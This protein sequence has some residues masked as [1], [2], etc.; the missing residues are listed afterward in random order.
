MVAGEKLDARH[1]E[2]ME[3]VLR[4]VQF[5][6]FDIE[7]THLEDEVSTNIYTYAW[8][9]T[10]HNVKEKGKIFLWWQCMFAHQYFKLPN[11]IR[12]YNFQITTNLVWYFMWFYLLLWYGIEMRCWYLA[13]L[14]HI[15]S[16][17]I[18]IMTHMSRCVMEMCSV[19]CCLSYMISI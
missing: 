2:A 8:K 10:Q 12:K 5:R 11:L 16:I 3:E 13:V 7:N 17:M 6:T 14:L 18:I 19:V 15:S 1:C 4:R 9:N